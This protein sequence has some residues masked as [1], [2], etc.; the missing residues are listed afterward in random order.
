MCQQGTELLAGGPAS[1]LSRLVR[2]S[3]K[4][5]NSVRDVWTSGIGQIT[6]GAEGFCLRKLFV[7][8]LYDLLPCHGC[9]EVC[10]QVRVRH[11]PASFLS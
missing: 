11:R 5:T 7:R 4:E 9:S 2:V 3:P 1:G 10:V 6:K 8:M